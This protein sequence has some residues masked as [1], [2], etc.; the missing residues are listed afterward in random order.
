MYKSFFLGL[1]T[2]IHLAACIAQTEFIPG[3]IITSDK[4][5]IVGNIDYGNDLSNFRKCSFR[6][7]TQ[8]FIT[9][10]YPGQIYGYRFNDSKYF[11]SKKIQ[12]GQSSTDV[13]MEYLIKGKVSIYYYK[14][15]IGDHFFI[16]KDSLPLKEISYSEAEVIID[17][18][19]Y[20]RNYNINR[21]VL[22]YYMKDCPELSDRINATKAPS[23][24]NLINL[25]ETYHNKV[26]KD[27][28]CVI[29]EKKLP[30][31]KIIIQ[32]LAGITKY[33]GYVS[34]TITPEIKGQTG[35]MCFIGLPLTSERLYFRTGFLYSR[36]QVE[37]YS[38][39]SSEPQYSTI[40]NFK[41]PLQFQYL[42]PKKTI[43][44]SFGGGMN[45]I[46]P[47]FFVAIALNAGVNLKLNPHLNLLLLS[48][49]DYISK[50]VIIPNGLIS[51][52]F[53]AGLSINL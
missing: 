52:S 38:R 10:Y 1:L 51:Y 5:T 39:Y 8:D 47:D 31:L 15:A 24:N 50:L 46:I 22:L 6:N 2:F 12:S 4:D 53:N 30:G 29:Y 26:C 20:A 49:L 14:D 34:K 3:Y 18:K 43:S 44:P 42:F 32:P 41:I 17:D 19:T 23:H 21:G 11:I 36:L 40:N 45:I 33:V 9:D 48:E 27:E 16:E 28:K 13:F 37:Q 25:V 35:L 7:N